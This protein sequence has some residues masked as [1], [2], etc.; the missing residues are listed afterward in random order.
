MADY[1]K[2]HM[3]VKESE[4]TLDRVFA[5]LQDL[6]QEQFVD[7]KHKGLAMWNGTV[8]PFDVQFLPMGTA[9]AE[10]VVGTTDSHGVRRSLVESGL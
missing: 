5:F 3:G 2:T 7:A 9:L 10:R 6:T 1:L 8:G 4:C